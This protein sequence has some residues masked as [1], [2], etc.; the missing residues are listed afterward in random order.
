MLRPLLRHSSWNAVATFSHQGSTFVS[1]F[2]VIKLLD[3]ATYGKYS[4]VNLTAFYFASILQFAVG[5]TASKFVARYVSDQEQL[6]SVI[7]ICGAFTFASGLF[8][9]GILALTSG[10]LAHSVFIEPSLAW[11]LA[12]ASLSVPGLIGMVFLGGLLQGLHCFR[13]L[14]ISSALS[15]LLF[16]AT[17]TA[18]AWTGDLTSAIWG[19]VVGSTLR[20][21]I[22]GAVTLLCLRGMQVRRFSWRKMHR[23]IAREISRFQIPA[24]LAG[25]VTLPTLWL[26]PTILTRNTQNFSDV[27]S[28]SVLIMLKTLIVLPASVISIALQPSAEKACAAQ[29]LDVAMRVFRTSSIAAFAFAAI[30]GLFFAVFAKEVLAI[31]GRSF[32]GASFELQLIMIAAVAESVAVTLYM[33]IQAASRMWSSIFATLLPRDVT[34]LVIV[35]AFTTEYGLQAAILAHVAGSIVNLC[36]A[37]WLGAKA[38]GSL[39]SSS[40]AMAP[41][42][43]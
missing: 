42:L 18:G 34:M 14:A 9:L 32:A 28:Y 30:A 23:E 16:V 20:C 13:E 21:L 19:F 35:T 36:G 10:F 2:L 26:I 25:F 38:V 8:G 6:F 11:P 27:A 15:S 1:N 5:S 3:H 43:P 29:Q 22:M 31:F 37:Y 41:S 17:V 7:W 4:L 39:R 24:G 33:R 40:R 12:I